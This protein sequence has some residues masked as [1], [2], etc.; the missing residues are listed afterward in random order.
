VDDR[1]LAAAGSSVQRGTPRPPPARHG[2]R[3]HSGRCWWRPAPPRLEPE[4]APRERTRSSGA[5]ARWAA[6]VMASTRCDGGHTSTV[7]QATDVAVRRGD[8]MPVQ[9]RTGQKEDRCRRRQRRGSAWPHC[10]PCFCFR[11]YP[12][13]CSRGHGRSATGRAATSAASAMPPGWRGTPAHL[14]WARPVRPF[15]ESCADAALGPSWN[16]ALG[17]SWNAALEAWAFIGRDGVEVTGATVIGCGH[18]SVGW[19]RTLLDG[20]V[21]LVAVRGWRWWRRRAGWS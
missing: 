16:A 5:H 14:R 19:R 17:P 20:Q 12:T 6:S 1:G 4:Q 9:R 21:W 2:T 3:R 13:G 8:P 15:M 11:T 7:I 18:R 10:W